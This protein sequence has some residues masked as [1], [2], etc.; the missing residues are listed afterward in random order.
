M[1]VICQDNVTMVAATKI[2]L[3]KLLITPD[4]VEVNACCAPITSEF[5]LDISAPV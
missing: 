4:N 5:N 3:N 1:S 2:K